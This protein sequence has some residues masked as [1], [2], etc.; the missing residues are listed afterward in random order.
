[1]S[2]R[3][4]AEEREWHAAFNSCE[5]VFSRGLIMLLIVVQFNSI[6]VYLYSQLV[7]HFH[8]Q[9][10]FFLIFSLKSICDKL[11]NWINFTISL[12]KAKIS[13]GQ[14]KMLSYEN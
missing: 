6:Y 10:T 4:F 3:A 12:E 9:R 13:R 1:M 8:H 5:F 2:I 11:L 7:S 14:T